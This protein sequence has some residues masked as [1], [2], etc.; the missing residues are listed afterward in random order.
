MDD[1]DFSINDFPI[2]N[3]VD[4]LFSHS[5]FNDQLGQNIPK[6]ENNPS[7]YSGDVTRCICGSATDNGETFVQCDGCDN[8]QHASCMGLKSDA[9]PEKYYCE[10]CR[11][12]LHPEL[13]YRQKQYQQV[14]IL[15]QETTSDSLVNEFL[16][17]EQLVDD[18]SRKRKAND[19]TPEGTMFPLGIAPVN[20]VADPVP[21][22]PDSI[23]VFAPTQTDLPVPPPPSVSDMTSQ[24]I[25]Q[26]SDTL[27]SYVNN[28]RSKSNPKPTST[29][30]PTPAMDRDLQEFTNIEEIP[31]KVR[32]SVAKAWL[33]ALK[34]MVEKCKTESA[35]LKFPDLVEFALQL[36]RTM[37][38]E[39]SYK[40]DGN[41]IPN[42]AYRD[43]FRNIK[44]NLTDDRN[45]HLRASLFK[46]EITPVQ[47]V[48]M[49][50]EE[51]ANPDLKVFAE[52]IRQQS[53]ENTIL[54]EH[55]I[56]KPR[57]YEDGETEG[58]KD[59][60]EEMSPAKSGTQKRSEQPYEPSR[61]GSPE[62]ESQQKENISS[63]GSR[64]DGQS[65]ADSSK[66]GNSRDA[67]SQPLTPKVSHKE[68]LATVN[69][70][71]LVEIDDPNIADILSDDGSTQTPPY[72]PTDHSPL[73]LNENAIWEGRIKMASVAEFPAKGIQ[74][75]GSL[76]DS[77]LTNE[78]LSSTAS[79]DGRISMESTLKYLQALQHSPSKDILAMVF[80]PTNSD[81]HGFDTLFDYFLKRN[82]YGVLRSKSPKVKDAYIVPLMPSPGKPP[83]ILKY[84][85]NSSFPADFK[86]RVLLGL[87]IIN[88]TNT[89]PVTRDGNFG[90]DTGASS[91]SQQNTPSVAPKA[92]N[93]PPSLVPTGTSITSDSSSSSHVSDVMTLFTPADCHFLKMLLETDQQIR[94]N[95]SLAFNPSFLQKLVAEHIKLAH[96]PQLS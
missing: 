77:T 46:G 81:T 45:P 25:V 85:P 64:S 2:N 14:D 17:T 67:S 32:Q 69:P 83:E 76:M 90:K 87:F 72:S 13:V 41:A 34:S 12:D 56:P 6:R 4:V 63:E 58:D 96:Y 11:P 82:R 53:T 78:I 57:K 43:K 3:N 84:L 62:S 80:L 8:W 20:T 7:S 23:Q 10:L 95:P 61:V 73:F 28:K 49:T 94:A 54:K 92:F 5:E 88:K 50:S 35:N 38:I 24:D 29:S 44:F 15:P 66:E 59:L 16:N 52:Q 27:P 33:S 21:S 39:L 19:F 86:E 91:V 60:K 22:I 37:F 71:D 30:A 55:H 74:V 31:N 1:I 48:H 79:L 51:M 68:T 47:L 18:N 40:I 36:E 89:V 70:A 9:L 65:A 42:K 93:N 26:N 75:A